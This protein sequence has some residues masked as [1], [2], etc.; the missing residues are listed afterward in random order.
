MT[1]R[2]VTRG[3]YLLFAVFCLLLLR[4]IA[5]GRTDD[6]TW[7]TLQASEVDQ[8]SHPIMVNFHCLICMIGFRKSTKRCDLN[9]FIIPL[10]MK[11]TIFSP[12]LFMQHRSMSIME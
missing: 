9:P 5:A 3:A 11:M 7:K 1:D 8:S 10:L 2:N 12:L 4:T 6:H